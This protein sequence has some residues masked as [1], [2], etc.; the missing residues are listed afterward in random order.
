MI[1]YDKSNDERGYGRES[2]RESGGWKPTEE[3]PGS[4][5][6]RAGAA[7]GSRSRE[8]RVKTRDLYE[9]TESVFIHKFEWYRGFSFRRFVSKHE[10]N[11]LIFYFRRE[12]L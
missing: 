7:I 5:A 6:F 9:S 1:Q 8:R 11:L 4:M 12:L 2:H 3:A 10:A